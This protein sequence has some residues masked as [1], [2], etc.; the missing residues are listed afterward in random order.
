MV[1][2]SRLYVV[3]KVSARLRAADLSPLQMTTQNSAILVTT[4]R[5]VWLVLSEDG[6]ISL[7]FFLSLG[8]F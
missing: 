3:D 2:A 4:C 7:P 1:A 6:I 8:E 5:A